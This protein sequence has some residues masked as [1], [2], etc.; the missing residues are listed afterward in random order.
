MQPGA[1]GNNPGAIIFA[2]ARGI[3]RRDGSGTANQAARKNLVSTTAQ[4][5]ACVKLTQACHSR[6]LEDF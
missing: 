5:G 6:C 1:S 2:F 3:K 4:S